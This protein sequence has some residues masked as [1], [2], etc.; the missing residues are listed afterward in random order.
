MKEMEV[1]TFFQTVI[2]DTLIEDPQTQRV[3]LCSGKV[4][5]D[6]LEEREKRELQNVAIVRLEQ[7]YPF[8][9]E[10]LLEALKPY[11]QAE[12]IWCQEEPMNM[13]AWSFLDRRLESVLTELG[14]KNTRPVYVGRKA[15]ASPATGVLTRHTLEQQELIA[16]ALGLKS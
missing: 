10:Q 4:Y 2:P 5:Y 1:G 9:R 8:P 11:K 12:L 13:G 15:A 6:L 7:F 3:V 16:Q 14:T